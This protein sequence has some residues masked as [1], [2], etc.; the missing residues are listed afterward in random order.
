LRG[1]AASVELARPERRADGSVLLRWRTLADA[2]RYRVE[3]F[4]APGATVAEA[5][6]SDT[7]YV[8]APAVAASA[9]G[10]LSWMVTA[11]RAD[12]AERSSPMGRI[13]P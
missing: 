5:V 13:A 7:S 8:V 6:V 9:A 3:V 4:T 2:A 12:G 10:P 11:I 1:D